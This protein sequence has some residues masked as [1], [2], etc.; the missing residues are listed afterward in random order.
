ME[1]TFLTKSELRG[2]LRAQIRSLSPS[3]RIAAAERIARQVECDSRF[4]ASKT[5]AV[6]MPLGDEP[7]IREAVERWAAEK[8]VVVPRIEGDDR[9]RFF[10]FCAEQMASGAFGIEEPQATAECPPEEIEVMVVPGVAFTAE[11]ARMGRGRGYYDRYLGAPAAARIY[12]IGTCFA[13]QLVEQL[14]VE[15]HDVLMDRV[16]VG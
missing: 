14:I 4:I 7:P 1:R 10:D 2:A 11:G 8:R 16:V 6:F 13:C 5:V 9:M 12:K 15:P 3:E